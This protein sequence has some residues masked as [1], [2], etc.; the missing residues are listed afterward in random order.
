M[1]SEAA[2]R[3]PVRKEPPHICLYEALGALS[4]AVEEA[5]T[6]ADKVRGVTTDIPKADPRPPVSGLMDVLRNAPDVIIAEVTELMKTLEDME[7]SL[8][9]QE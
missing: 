5:A 6:F 7:R 9:T 2:S 4:N 3:P 1:N 8:F